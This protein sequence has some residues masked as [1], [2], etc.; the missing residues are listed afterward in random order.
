MSHGVLLDTTQFTEQL[1]DSQTRLESARQRAI[2]A[3]L[4]WSLVITVTLPAEVLALQHLRPLAMFIP[5]ITLIGIVGVVQAMFSMVRV[6]EKLDLERVALRATLP[7]MQRLRSELSLT[8]I[9]A[10][11]VDLK[12]RRGYGYLDQDVPE[13]LEGRTPSPVGS[14]PAKALARVVDTNDPDATLINARVTQLAPDAMDFEH[15][16]DFADLE[17]HNG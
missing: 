1:L 13:A 3:I 9:H 11:L 17:K 2:D 6:G 14:T 10:T 7:L 5:V 15:H 8:I 12:I 4:R 16:V